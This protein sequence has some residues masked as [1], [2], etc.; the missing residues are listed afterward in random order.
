MVLI[1]HEGKKS[2]RGCMHE[3]RKDDGVL[4]MK[5]DKY[6]KFAASGKERFLLNQHS[7][8]SQSCH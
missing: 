6:K 5:K 7:R 3:S 4:W 8:T 1:L 2:W